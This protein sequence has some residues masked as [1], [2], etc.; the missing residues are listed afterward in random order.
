MSLV[1]GHT[2]KNA[3]RWFLPQ[4]ENFLPLTVGHVIVT[5]ATSSRLQIYGYLPPVPGHA[6]TTS[7]LWFLA[8]KSRP[9]AFSVLGHKATAPASCFWPQHAANTKDK[10]SL[11]IYLSSYMISD[12]I[13]STLVSII[14]DVANDNSR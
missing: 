4:S 8:I 9:L 12:K 6:A 13:L 10:N 14:C 5:F 2:M 11:C 3:C 1:F 7:F